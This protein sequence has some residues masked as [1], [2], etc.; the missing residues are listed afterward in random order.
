M[1]EELFRRALASVPVIRRGLE[2]L[3]GA[4]R[5]DDPVALA[6]AATLLGEAGGAT[7]NAAA[8]ELLVEY[9]RAREVEHRP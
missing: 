5:S 8:L 7:E 2:A 4:T 9:A 3:K 6:K 1:T